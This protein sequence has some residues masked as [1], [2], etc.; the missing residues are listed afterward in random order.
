[1]AL[2]VVIARILLHPHRLSNVPIEE[3]T[4][5]S[6]WSTEPCE[7]LTICRCH[8]KGSTFV[9]SLVKTLGAGPV[10][11]RI[12]DLSL[13]RLTLLRCLWSG[14]RVGAVIWGSAYPLS[15]SLLFFFSLVGQF[16]FTL[17]IERLNRQS[18]VQG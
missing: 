11:I 10:G 12:C 16:S 5:I 6:T 15:L 14:V 9:L 7:G 3:R 17:H 18:S 13:C 8:S 1:M 2:G 4:A